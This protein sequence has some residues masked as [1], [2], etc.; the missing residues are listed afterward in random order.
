MC[1]GVLLALVIYGGLLRWMYRRRISVCSHPLPG[2][3]FVWNR[4]MPGECSWCDSIADYER[5]EHEPGYG[6][7]RTRGR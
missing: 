7:Y 1:G 2:P 3:S 5:T 6:P 4:C